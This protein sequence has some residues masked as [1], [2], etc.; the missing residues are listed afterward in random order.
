M[1]WWKAIDDRSIDCDA[2]DMDTDPEAVINPWI[3]VSKTK[4]NRTFLQN[5][6]S[7]IDPFPKAEVLNLQTN[8]FHNLSLHDAVVENAALNAAGIQ[9]PHASEIL[10]PPPSPGTPSPPRKKSKKDPNK[11]CYFYNCRSPQKSKYPIIKVKEDS[12]NRQAS[13]TVVP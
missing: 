2:V 13:L 7:S 5:D 6:P 4:R 12:V 8:T 10:H 3:T 1:K 9:S 11:V